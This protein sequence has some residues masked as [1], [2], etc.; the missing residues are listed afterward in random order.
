MP[1]SPRR[2]SGPRTVTVRLRDAQFTTIGRSVSLPQAST[3]LGELRGAA[4]AALRAATEAMGLDTEEESGAGARLLGGS[5]GALSTTA[6]LALL[7][8]E[9]APISSADPAGPA[10]ARGD[11]P[12][13]PGR[14][15]GGSG[16]P[17]R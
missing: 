3:E 5:L 17:W 15:P 6:Q 4:G 11:L 12:V 1:A 10:D 14:S 7:P 8:G 9:A 13:V 2:G 16:A